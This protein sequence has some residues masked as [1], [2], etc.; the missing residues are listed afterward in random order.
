MRLEAGTV[1]SFRAAVAELLPER[2]AALATYI[3]VQARGAAHAP[4]ALCCNY[5][6]R[7]LSAESPATAIRFCLRALA[8]LPPPLLPSVGKE[9]F[10]DAARSEP[11]AVRKLLQAAREPAERQALHRLG[12]SAGVVEFTQHYLA[13]SPVPSA[14]LTLLRTPDEPP[15]S[16]APPRAVAT[17]ASSLEDATMADVEGRP[18]GPERQ[19]AVATPAASEEAGGGMGGHSAGASDACIEICE[20]IGA[21]FG[22]GLD[23]QL[24]GEGKES[25]ERLR[26][27]TMRSIQRLAAE[28][29]GGS[30]HFVLE[31]V[32]NADDNTFATGVTPTLRIRAAPEQI[33]FFNNEVGF[34]ERNVLALC[35]MGESTKKASDAGYIGNKGIGFKSVFKLSSQPRVH[36][37][38]YHLQFNSSGDGLGYIVPTP[39][40]PPVGWDESGGTSVVLP[41]AASSAEETLRGFR[42]HIA[43]IQPSLLLFLHR[44]QQLELHDVLA[45]SIRTLTRHP[46]P[47]DQHVVVLRE[48][49]PPHGSAVGGTSAD[50]GSAFEAESSAAQTSR[51]SRWL[52][53]REELRTKVARLGI[54]LTEI[55]LAFPLDAEL[56]PLPPLEVCA[57]LP[58]RTYGLRFLLQ[59]DF[60]VPSSRESVDSS[61]EWNQWLRDEVTPA[62]S[63]CPSLHLLIA[64]S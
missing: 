38:Q 22:Q 9:V 35:S 63:K 27:V 53:V 31:L 20:R 55:A 52:V 41:L 14:P 45:G 37:R 12:R 21:R 61:S 51:S 48:T 25:L 44:L 4:L 11:D 59:A 13:F 57:Y 62:L 32:Q 26:A 49:V 5:A 40:A 24:D 28:L 34:S 2:A 56:S 43:Q 42:V 46:D 18:S 33:E 30:V 54:E 58:L 39:I 15:G 17:P 3:C 8:A 16:S 29:Y 7:A 60:V 10:L 47:H 50:D 36:S 64:P 1:E 23:L 6:Q 19:P